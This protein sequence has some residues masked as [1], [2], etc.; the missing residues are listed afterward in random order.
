MYVGSN[1]GL[2][3][4][5]RHL[6]HIFVENQNIGNLAI[7]AKHLKPWPHEV[8]KR[9]SPKPDWCEKASAQ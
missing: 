6:I 4:D 9:L 2:D 3:R 1:F 5:G 7:E 8:S